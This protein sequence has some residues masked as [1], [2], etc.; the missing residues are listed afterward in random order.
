M[1]TWCQS[2]SNLKLRN[3]YTFLMVLLMSNIVVYIVGGID[4]EYLFH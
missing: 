3:S 1:V 4:L 2:K